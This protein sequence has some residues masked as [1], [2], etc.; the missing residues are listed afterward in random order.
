[1]VFN[2]FLD[3]F[4]Q[5]AMLNINVDK[6]GYNAAYKGLEM[7]RSR[8]FILSSSDNVEKVQIHSNFF[9][10]KN[11]RNSSTISTMKN[12]WIFLQAFFIVLIIFVLQLK[13]PFV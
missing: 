13:P 6:E 4:K 9:I 2:N 10:P 7:Q 3:I 5:K 12:A 11:G 8:D 1:M